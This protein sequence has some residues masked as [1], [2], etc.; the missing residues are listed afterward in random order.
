MHNP[1][2][3]SVAVDTAWPR[4]TEICVSY[5]NDLN[6]AFEAVEKATWL[7]K[8]EYVEYV[9]SLHEYESERSECFS[10]LVEVSSSRMKISHR[11]GRPRAVLVRSPW[12]T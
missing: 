5:N 7:S 11:V 8:D 12:A 9:R 6:Q 4:S 2:A 10:A 1:E 3:I